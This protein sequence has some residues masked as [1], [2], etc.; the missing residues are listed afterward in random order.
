MVTDKY[1]GGDSI[2]KCIW[3]KINEHMKLVTVYWRLQPDHMVSN[4]THHKRSTDQV[5]CVG[6]TNYSR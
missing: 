1:A 4:G 3:M 6:D 2:N 5:Q